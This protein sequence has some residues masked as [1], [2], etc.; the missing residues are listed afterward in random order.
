MA[1]KIYVFT[2]DG[3]GHCV[4]LKNK[5]HEANIPFTEIEITVNQ[6]LWEQVVSQTDN[7]YLPTIYIQKGDSSSG[8]VYVPD[9]DFTSHEELV[10]ML[11][12][13]KVGD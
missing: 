3:C 4:Q 5:L 8:P 12:V 1:D 2:L 6:N 7:E 13:Y 11:S 9:R 10:E